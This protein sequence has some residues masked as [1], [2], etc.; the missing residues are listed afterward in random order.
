MRESTYKEF[1]EC[2]PE[3][4]KEKAKISDTQKFYISSS[5]LNKQ[6]NKKLRLVGFKIENRIPKFFYVED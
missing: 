5:E 1:S 3:H 2:F 6:E 4:D